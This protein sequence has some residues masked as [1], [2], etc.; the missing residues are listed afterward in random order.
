MANRKARL[1]WS[2]TALAGL[3]LAAVVG[4][5]GLIQRFETTPAPAREPPGSWPTASG[6]KL[7]AERPTLLLFVHPRCPC[8]RATIGELAVLAT[9][10]P[11]RFDARVLF[12]KPAGAEPGWEQT[13]TWH[14]ARRIPGVAVGIDLDGREAERFAAAASGQALLYG[15]D[16]GLLFAGGITAARG[17]AGDSAGRRSLIALLTGGAAE[18]DRTPV[19]GCPLSGDG[20]P[21]R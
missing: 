5:F 1:C 9:H 14:A 7:T 10:C 11:G 8:T 21:P 17:N 4:G 20:A 6:I 12:Y 18:T 2:L 16:G 3:W 15:P 13:D 19:F